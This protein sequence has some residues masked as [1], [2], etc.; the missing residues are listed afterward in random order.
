M[1]VNLPVENYSQTCGKPCGK[2]YKLWKTIFPQVIIN[3]ENV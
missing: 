1:T 2:L 3:C